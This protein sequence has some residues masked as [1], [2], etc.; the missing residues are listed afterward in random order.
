[1]I[2][3]YTFTHRLDDVEVLTSIAG[4]AAASFAPFV[5]A[6]GSELL[7]LDDLAMMEQPVNLSASV[8]QLDF[9]KWR[10]FRDHPDARFVGLA[11]PRVL[12]RRPHDDISGPPVDF[13]FAEDVAGPDRSR[14]LWGNPAF[15]FAAVVTRAYATSGWFADI[16]GAFRGREEGGL[17]TGLPGDWFRTDPL[18]VAV[19]STTEVCVNEVQEQELCKL[20]LMPLCDCKD[21]GLSVFYT[22]QSAYRP[23]N[24]DDAAATASERMESMLQY[25]LCASRFAHYV[26][27]LARD[28]VGSLKSASDIQNFFNNWLVKY[29]TTDSRASPSTRAR[30]PLRVGEV[31][32]IDL[33]GRPGHYQLIMRLCPHYQL[34]QLHATIRLVS[35]IASA[36]A[37]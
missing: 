18:G 13:T 37:T 1:L 3:D 20:G 31:E 26:K 28:K 16:R 27:V 19:K 30:Y 6:A 35:Q 36:T 23:K 29:V 5:A 34:D 17:V 22:N 25:T 10:A 21:T 7:G 11:L 32:V 33:P 9:L 4:V 2:G 24:Y 8:E 12:L 15:A 14:Y